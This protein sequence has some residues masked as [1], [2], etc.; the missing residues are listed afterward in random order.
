MAVF[1]G[2]YNFPGGRGYLLVGG[3]RNSEVVSAFGLERKNMS[4]KGEVLIGG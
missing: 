2:C 4:R 1:C 3:S